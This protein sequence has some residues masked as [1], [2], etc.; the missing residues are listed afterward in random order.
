[1][2]MTYSELS[3]FGRLRKVEK[4]GPYGMF[5]RLLHEWSHLFSPQEISEKTRRFFYYYCINRHKQVTLTP[6]YHMEQY[7]T[8]DHRFD[9]RPFLYPPFT[10]TNRA[11]ERAIAAM[12]TAGTRKPEVAGKED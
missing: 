10:F 12:G 11:I 5:C 7:A 6:S 8:N 3:V 9:L 4:L 1:M 2:G